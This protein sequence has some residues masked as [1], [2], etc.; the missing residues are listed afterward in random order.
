M[1]TSSQRLLLFKPSSSQAWTSCLSFG[2]EKR[3]WSS[4]AT[5][6]TSFEPSM[7]TTLFPPFTKPGHRSSARDQPWR[8]P[9]EK[10]NPRNGHSSQTCTDGSVRSRSRPV[11]PCPGGSTFKEME[12]RYQSPFLVE[13]TCWK[14]W[15]MRPRN[16]PASLTTERRQIRDST[17]EVS[18]TLLRMATV[19]GP[20][21]MSRMVHQR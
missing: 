2:I 3:L 13:V 16:K 6:W 15:K 9:N 12:Q 20:F 10:Q 17:F 8:S 14:R 7:L 19:L 11:W 5:T 21:I 4:S 1:G 18:V